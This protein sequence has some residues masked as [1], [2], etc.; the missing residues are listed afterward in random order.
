MINEIPE[1]FEAEGNTLVA[2]REF[3]LRRG[4]CCQCG[5]RNCPYGRSPTTQALRH[6]VLKQSVEGS[7][8]E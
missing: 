4:Y 5:C 7:S 8:F 2:T 3:L 1:G 6:V